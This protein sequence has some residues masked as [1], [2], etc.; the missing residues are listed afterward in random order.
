MKKAISLWLWLFLL[1]IAFCGL[2]A[3]SV[4]PPY[5]SDLEKIDLAAMAAGESVECYIVYKEKDGD[6]N[7]LA[8]DHSETERERGTV[9]ASDERLYV[10]FTPLLEE[11]RSNSAYKWK[12]T[13]VNSDHYKVEWA[14]MVD[15]AKTK[16]QYLD[17]KGLLRSNEESTEWMT[18]YLFYTGTDGTLNS[19]TMDTSQPVTFGHAKASGA[20]KYCWKY[21][22]T[23]QRLS[24]QNANSKDNC[25]HSLD[26]YFLEYVVTSTTEDDIANYETAYEQAVQVKETMLALDSDLSNLK[27]KDENDGG[28][29]DA[30]KI[31]IL[32]QVGTEYTSGKFTTESSVV[33]VYAAIDVL[34]SVIGL[35]S[36][37]YKPKVE[38]VQGWY[39]VKAKENGAY[40]DSDSKFVETAEKKDGSQYFYMRCEVSTATTRAMLYSYDGL[41]EGAKHRFGPG[42]SFIELYDAGD[43]GYFVKTGGSD[44]SKW[45]GLNENGSPTTAS[46]AD[47]LDNLLFLD[48]IPVGNDEIAVATVEDGTYQLAFNGENKGEFAVADGKIT[49]DAVPYQLVSYSGMNYSIGDDLV[50]TLLPDFTVN[51]YKKPVNALPYPGFRL[52]PVVD[53]AAEAVAV[54]TLTEFAEGALEGKTVTASGT[55]DFANLEAAG[56]AGIVLNPNAAFHAHQPATLTAIEVSYTRAFNPDGTTCDNKNGNWQTICL[57]FDVTTVTAMQNGEEIELA[58]MNSLN[59]EDIENGTETRR[60]FWLYEVGETNALVEATE[61]KANVAYLM[62]V[63]YA[64]G[65]Y[66]PFYNV[67]GDVTFKG[68]AIA[69]TVLEEKATST[70]SMKGNYKPINANETVF[71]GINENGT[72]FQKGVAIS[73]FSAVVEAV[74]LPA[75]ASPLYLD[76]F[77]RD[78]NQTALPASVKNNGIEVYPVENGVMVQSDK[79]T[80]VTVYRTDGARQTVVNV[81]EGINYVGLPAGQYVV[82]GKVVIV[83]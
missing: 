8:L 78:D 67:R 42:S 54:S 45:T 15:Y 66:S 40:L 60:P 21:D 34:S 16:Y 1:P 59:V 27:A 3:Q 61:M 18:F 38:P 69:A 55:V 37:F 25:A 26:F 11:D 24:N 56:A 81:T 12:V 53:E 83:K 57:P 50:A 2:K 62:A 82:N 48:F 17:E 28:K 80:V 36:S 65:T 75:G 14:S 30:A 9:G 4:T 43:Y 44:P 77:G 73:S 23:N 13:K 63:P 74:N 52:T 49:V 41:K 31:D 64:P 79:A 71:Y 46:K 10:G 35:E 29:F 68:S 39:R 20:S 47:Y 72:A 33:D 6:G 22:A 19:G 76:I 51:T 32:L 70:Y 58:P 7:W 5:L